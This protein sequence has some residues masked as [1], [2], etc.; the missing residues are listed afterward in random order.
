[1]SG[2]KKIDMIKLEKD[3]FTKLRLNALKTA[4]KYSWNNRAKKIIRFVK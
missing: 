2:K 1:M 3:K 4:K